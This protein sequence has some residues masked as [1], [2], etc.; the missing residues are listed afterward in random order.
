MSKKNE[1]AGVIVD[2]APTLQPATET[3]TELAKPAASF[4]D[5]FVLSFAD[6][7]PPILN[8]VQKTSEIK[9]ETGSITADKNYVLVEP[10]GETAAIVLAA[11]KSWVEDIPYDE[12]K[13]AKTAA[14]QE[15]A[16]ILARE[17]DYEV[18]ESAKLILLIPQPAGNENDDAYPYP[19]GGTNYAL[20]RLYV[21]KGAYRSTYGR[22]ANW[23]LFNPDK[24]LSSVLWKLKSQKEVK[25]KYTFFAPALAATTA[26]PSPEVAAFLA[27]LGA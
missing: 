2:D 7:D 15:D 12:D 24:P 11:I 20:G 27:K 19:I 25:G 8:V 18:V 14:T 4:T 1:N 17:S 10:E 3:S 13:Q 9:A 6:L 23:K 21:R 5:G 26:T 16:I 22:I